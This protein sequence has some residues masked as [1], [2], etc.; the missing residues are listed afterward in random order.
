MKR[1]NGMYPGQSE[2]SS[3]GLHW[4]GHWKQF[5]CGRAPGTNVYLSGRKAAAVTTHSTEKKLPCF[6]KRQKHSCSIS[7]LYSH[8]IFTADSPCR[9][10]NYEQCEPVIIT[11][12]HH[13]HTPTSTYTKAKIMHKEHVCMLFQVHVVSRFCQNKGHPI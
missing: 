7:Q 3:Q 8:K 4:Q 2:K 10:Y 9:L 13:F 5:E 12:R 1:N 11:M 6:S